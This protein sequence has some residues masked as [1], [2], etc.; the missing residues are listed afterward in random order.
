MNL[1]DEAFR[2]TV[3]GRKVIV[4]RCRDIRLTSWQKVHQASYETG[5]MLGDL[6]CMLGQLFRANRRKGT[7]NASLAFAGQDRS[8]KR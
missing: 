2:A 3:S 8:G 4:C 1:A 6:W 5:L 7:D